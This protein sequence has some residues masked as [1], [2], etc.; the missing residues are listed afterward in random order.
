MIAA[1]KPLLI[2]YYQLRSLSQESSEKGGG[3]M[4]VRAVSLSLI[5]SLVIL[6]VSAVNEGGGRVTKEKHDK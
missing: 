5:L 3:S 4:A 1:P 2:E 6:P